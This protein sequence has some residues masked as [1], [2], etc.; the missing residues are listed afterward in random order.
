MSERGLAAADEDGI[1]AADEENKNKGLRKRISLTN[2]SLAPSLT[3][4]QRRSSENFVKQQ[5]VTG[6]T[7]ADQAF[8]ICRDAF[9]ELSSAYLNALEK[10]VSA[11]PLSE[12]LKTHI[13]KAVINAFDSL[14]TQM[15][16]ADRAVGATCAPSTSA[17]TGAKIYASTCSAQPTI[18]RVARSPVLDIPKTTN[19]IV[20]PT[21]ESG[22][23]TSRETRS[24]LEKSL[25][26]SEY[27][28]KICRIS[29]VKK[30][31]IR[32]EAHSVDLAKLRQSQV[33]DKVGLRLEQ[34]TKINPRLIVHGVPCGMKS[35]DLKKEIIS[36]N[37]KNVT[38][39]DIRVIYVFP[40]RENRKFTSCVIEVLPAIRAQ[41]LKEELIFVNYSVCKIA[42]YVKVLQ[43]YRCL[44]FGHFAKTCKFS[45]RCGYCAEG[46]ETRDC[47]TRERDPVC[48]NCMR[49]LPHEERSHSALD[50]R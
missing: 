36:L 33:L 30:N 23:A 38:F 21:D 22:L 34:E 42:D 32:I 35:E 37:L 29:S 3:S 5:G 4:T 19:L 6:E 26:P 13:D 8:R 24:V 27:D 20:T 50:S 41:L 25:K 15:E 16:H 14:R 11:P 1:E 10:H 40:P 9:L 46:H 47:V 28:L 17:N 2:V 7:E 48:G 43:C 45:P 49:W 18:H 31:G 44:A 39:P 12:E